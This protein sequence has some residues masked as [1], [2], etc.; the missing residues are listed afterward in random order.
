MSGFRKDLTVLRQSAG[1]YVD[2]V[3]VPGSSSTLTIQASVQPVKMGRDMQALPEGRHMS[4]YK[5]IYCAD[6]LNVTAD[7]EGVQPDKIVHLGYVYE[8]IDLDEAQSDVI[9][10]YRYLAV[11]IAKHS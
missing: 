11:K 5:K 8:I 10:H 9:N 4:D 3:F 2:G 6:R 7:G 1:A